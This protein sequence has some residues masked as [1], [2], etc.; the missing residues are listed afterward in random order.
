MARRLPKPS[1]HRI[2]MELMF[3]NQDAQGEW[4]PGSRESGFFSSVARSFSVQGATVMDHWK[5]I[6]DLFADEQETVDVDTFLEMAGSRNIPAPAEEVSLGQARR[7]IDR[8]D[9]E[10]RAT[11][12]ESNVR[13]A[14]GSF[15]GGTAPWLISPEGAIGFAVP[16]L[17]AASI[18]RAVGSLGTQSARRTNSVLDTAVEQTGTR[19]GMSGI[20]GRPTA[21]SGAAREL[22]ASAM[23]G[24]TNLLAQ[25]AAYG[26]VDPLEAALAFGAPLAFGAGIGAVQGRRAAARA[27]ATETSVDAPPRSANASPDETQ[28]PSGLQKELT[29]TLGL[30]PE[31]TTESFFRKLDDALAKNN[32]SDDAADNLREA[33]ARTGTTRR[34]DL[35]EGMRRAMRQL[36]EAERIPFSGTP[37]ALK[38]RI[39][40][41]GKKVKNAERKVKRAEKALLEAGDDRTA[42]R[43]ASRKLRQENQALSTARA[44]RNG[45]TG[46]ST[47]SQ[48]QKR[49]L[50]EVDS[51]V[52]NNPRLQKQRE[53]IEQEQKALT[54]AQA[55]AKTAKNAEEAK[56][57]QR[58]VEAAQERV[59]AAQGRL[60][61]LTQ[62]TRRRLQRR[63][64]LE[65]AA[66][67]M[68]RRVSTRQ[69]LRELSEE[70][71]KTDQPLPAEFVAEFLEIYQNRRPIS[72]KAVQGMQINDVN[73]YAQTRQSIEEMVDADPGMRALKGKPGYD[74]A[75]E[76]QARHEK[77]LEDCPL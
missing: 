53:L 13:S 20:G 59:D 35:P 39:A 30:T 69:A 15:L 75:V 60:E 29:D 37:E 45:L 9:R 40:E 4:A 44:E 61:D 10:Q 54:T 66:D 27:R 77:I 1:E 48:T 23:V 38:S 21:L 50:A 72:P 57:A 62:S 42:V 11:Q 71:A 46:K 17:R 5:G 12:Y 33:F 74:E 55:A 16:P 32:I 36:D 49:M 19:T 47:S 3:L 52:E 43:A 58:K 34:Q 7:L 73:D 31:D 14:I 8:F 24:G 26:E 70:V 68:A 64:G 63:A 25:Q 67:P 18:S 22:P 65:Q 51:Q 41:L 28:V 76:L 56:L 2:R 6:G